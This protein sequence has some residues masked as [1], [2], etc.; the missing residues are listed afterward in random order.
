MDKVTVY[1]FTKYDITTDQPQ[2][3]TR[4][5]TRKAIDRVNGT[6]LENTAVEVDASV[7]G[8]EIEGMT[9]RGFDPHAQRGFQ[10]VVGTGL[11]QP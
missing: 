7:V 3:S 10:T 11:R 4:W 8:S 2:K 1:R 5:A 9:A 6:V